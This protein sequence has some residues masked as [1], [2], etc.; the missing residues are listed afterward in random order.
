[1][2]T[3]LV[4]EDD[5]DILHVLRERL[6]KHGCTVIGALDGQKALEK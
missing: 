1:M 6:I 3:I 4:V 2:A 5:S